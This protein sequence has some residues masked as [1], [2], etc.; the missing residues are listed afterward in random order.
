MPDG[1]IWREGCYNR[2]CQA[3]TITML[4]LLDT[5]KLIKLDLHHN[6][7]ETVSYEEMGR[8]NFTLLIE[9]CWYPCRSVCLGVMGLTHM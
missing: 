7:L 1:Q 9:L 2:Q 4:S 3:G 6:T 5:C 8:L